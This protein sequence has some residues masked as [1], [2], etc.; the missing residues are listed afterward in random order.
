MVEEGYPV[1][2]DFPSADMEVEGEM[3]CEGSL[4]PAPAFRTPGLFVLSV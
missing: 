1:K 4:S 2:D 3:A